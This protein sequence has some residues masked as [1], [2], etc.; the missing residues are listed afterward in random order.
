MVIDL[1]LFA[2]SRLGAAIRNVAIQGALLASLPL[3]LAG[4]GHHLGHAV[5][6]AGGALAIKGFLIP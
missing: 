3:L 6:L 2:S 4:E 1:F 5:L